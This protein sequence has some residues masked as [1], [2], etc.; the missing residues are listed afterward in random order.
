MLIDSSGVVIFTDFFGFPN[1]PTQAVAEWSITAALAM[2]RSVFEL[3]RAGDIKFKTTKGI[4]GLSVGLIGLGR[5]GSAIARMIKVF[6]P[7]SVSYFNRT[8]K[9]EIESDFGVGYK[10]IDEIFRQSDIV[11][12][13]VPKSAGHEFIGEELL[14][15]MKKDSLLVNITHS[16]VI[17]EMALLKQLETGNIRAISDPPMTIDEFNGLPFD[18][19]YCFNGSN[20]FNTVSSIKVTSD[21]ATQSLINLVKIGEDEYRVN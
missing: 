4:K 8:R 9:Q 20:A 6:D 13:C 12:L 21:K 15:L 1:G 11:F 2:N 5:I 19:W 14:T 18:R 3:G 16:G 17:D 7:A 10:S